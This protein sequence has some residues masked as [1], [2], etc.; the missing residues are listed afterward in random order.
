MKENLIDFGLI[1]Q[2]STLT[3]AECA[4]YIGVS[5]SQMYNYTFNKMIPHYK[6]GKRCY[7]DRLEIDAWLKANRV[8]TNE[9]VE[10]KANLY[11]KGGV[12]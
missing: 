6:R 9:E 5:K 10:A 1:T 11:R 4:V 3:L 7:F 8:A 12:L 2:K